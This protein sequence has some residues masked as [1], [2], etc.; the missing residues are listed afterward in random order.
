MI[1]AWISAARS[2]ER[3]RGVGREER[4]ARARGEDHHAALLEV[5]DGPPADV[6]LGHRAHLDGGQHAR[7]KARLLERVLQRQR[8]DDGREHPHVVPLRAVHS[9]TRTFETAKDVPAADDDRRLD[10]HALDFSHILGN[11]G[12]DDRIDPVGLLAHEGFAGN[13]QE[14]TLVGERGRGSHET[15]L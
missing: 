4:V 10:A 1:S 6:G 11:L 5:A 7:L 3:G 9:R 13:F 14:D 12:R 2:A 8:V 15:R